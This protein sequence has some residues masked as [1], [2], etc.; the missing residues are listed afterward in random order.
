VPQQY[1]RELAAHISPV[2]RMNQP[3]KRDVPMRRRRTLGQRLSRWTRRSILEAAPHDIVVTERLLRVTNLIDPPQ[4]LLDPPLLARALTHRTR[5]SVA[6][7]L[8]K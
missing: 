6:R 1:C 4:R 5:Q 2:W 3:P 7:R 8:G